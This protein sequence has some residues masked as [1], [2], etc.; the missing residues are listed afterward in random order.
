MPPSVVS[1]VRSG[2]RASHRWSGMYATAI[3]YAHEAMPTP[4]FSEPRRGHV[5]VVGGGIVGLSCAEALSRDGWQVSLV[6]RG[7]ED[8]DGAS[9][10]NAGLIVPSHV[11]PLAAPGVM[12]Q[13][14]R[15]M[16]DPES[17]FFVAPRFDADLLHWGWRF[18]R[19]ATAAHVA[20]AVPVLG[21]LLMAG[22]RA[23]IELSGRVSGPT[24][25]QRGLVM[26]CLTESGLEE[27]WHEAQA[28]ISLG[29]EVR[30]VDAQEL[31]TVY[32]GV[33][34]AVAGGVWYHQD[35]HL[36]PR[37]LMTAL[38]TAVAARGAALHWGRQVVG[39]ERASR[40]ELRALRLDDGT[41][42]T[43]DAFVLAAGVETVGLTRGLGL[44]LPLQA[45]RG[46][47]VT[48]TQ[49]PE[50][51]EVP[52]ILSEARVA[53][54]PLP[55]GIRWGGTMEV[56]RPGRPANPRRLRG[57][58]KSVERYFPGFD[59][60]E[61]MQ[62]PMWTGWRPLSPDGLP[63]LGRLQR[64][65]NVVVATGHGMM[66]FSL[67]PVTGTLVADLLAERRPEMDLSPL[68]PERFA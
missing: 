57:I 5:V 6:E 45:G 50:R 38:Q 66:G 26:L 47:S 40:G 39:L 13:G 36:S 44:R 9:F 20:R 7:G 49:P 55:E 25:E 43:A 54:T 1:I 22:L 59:G 33:R 60:Q 58:A 30:K 41:V 3:R 12:R 64:A 53:M 56:A 67:G 19:S 42:L 65:A 62:L 11:V 46:Y 52:A 16:L 35:A 18:M 10:G 17:P 48:Q 63:Y 14:L 8:R 2:V 32:P 31:E 34:L 24:V 27:A 61:L 4:S 68:A 51:P 28:A 15:W 37:G 29:A 23:H 21:A